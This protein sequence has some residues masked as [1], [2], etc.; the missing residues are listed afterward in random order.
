MEGRNVLLHKIM[1]RIPPPLPHSPVVAHV[2]TPFALQV[3]NRRQQYDRYSKALSDMIKLYEN[4]S[5]WLHDVDTFTRWMV[6]NG[7]VRDVT[8]VDT[9]CTM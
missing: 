2:V 3:A 6:C 8:T 7:A 4:M 1:A 5:K 9:T